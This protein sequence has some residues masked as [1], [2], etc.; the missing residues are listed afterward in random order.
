VST[1]KVLR[2]LWGHA[3]RINSVALGADDSILASASYDQTVRLWDCRSQSQEPAQVLDDAKDSVTCVMVIETDVVASSVDGRIRTYDV[4]MGRLL[5]DVINQPVTWMCLSNDRNCILIT[6]LDDTLRLLEKQTGEL[7]NEYRGLVCRDYK[8]ESCLSRAD[9]YVV[10]ASEDGKVYFWDLVEGNVVYNFQAHKKT[11][12]SIQYH[13]SETCMITSCVDGTV[14]VWRD[15][16][17]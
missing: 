1:G 5:T 16:V 10:G 3:S 11:I 14:Y 12:S 8:T 9:A 7:L 2:K 15:Q 4:R 13:P 17:D 6:C